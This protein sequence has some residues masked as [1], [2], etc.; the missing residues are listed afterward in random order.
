MSWH[1]CF[2]IDL[3]IRLLLFTMER[4]KAELPVRYHGLRTK[5]PGCVTA[6][7]IDPRFQGTS[8]MTRISVIDYQSLLLLLC[9]TTTKY[10]DIIHR[11]M[12]KKMG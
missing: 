11:L 2:V 9:N 12:V 3:V 1:G 5:R 6:R 4:R 8:R 10:L 7:V